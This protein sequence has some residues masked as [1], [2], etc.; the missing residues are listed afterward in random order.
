LVVL[1]AL[2]KYPHRSQEAKLRAGAPL[3]LVSKQFTV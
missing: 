3:L 2:D 1:S